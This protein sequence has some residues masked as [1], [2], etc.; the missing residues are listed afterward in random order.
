MCSP[1][2]LILQIRM[3]RNVSLKMLSINYVNLFYMSTS[4]DNKCL[5]RKMRI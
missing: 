3:S 4:E 5:E 2:E 1:S